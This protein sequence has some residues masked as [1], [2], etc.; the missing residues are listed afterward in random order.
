MLGSNSVTE[1]D[2]LTDNG[3]YGFNGYSPA[4]D[5]NV[6]VANNEISDN[7]T[8]TNGYDHP[9]GISCGCAGGGKFWDTN[10]ITFT[11]NWV[12]NNYDPA[13]WLDTNNAGFDISG[14]YINNN[15]AEGIQVEI[16]YNGL[17]SDNTLVDNGWVY[18]PTNPDFPTGAI[19]ISESGG[20]SRVSS[21]YSG[22]LTITGNTLTDNWSGVVLWENSN[23]FCSDGSDGVCTLVAPSKYTIAS[24][25]ANLAT[26]TPGE[27][28]DYFDNCRWKTQNVS[29][30]GNTFNFTPANIPGTCTRATAC[31]QNA[32]FSEYGSDE[33]FTG[34]VVPT[35]ISLHQN[36]SFSDNTYTGP[37]S[38]VG[39]SQGDVVTWAQWTGGFTDGSG[40]GVT[41]PG[42]DS[43]S[44]Y[45]GSGGGGTTTTTTVPPTTTTTTVPPTTTT[46]TVPPTTT[47]TTTAPAP[48]PNPSF[49]LTTT[50]VTPTTVAPWWLGSVVITATVTPQDGG[51][52]TGTVTV[53]A[54]STPICYVTL[55]AGTGSCSPEVA[56]A[57]GS[58]AITGSYG[59]DTDFYGSTGLATTLTVA[60]PFWPL[61]MRSTSRRP[62]W[63]TATKR[64]PT[65]RLAS[66]R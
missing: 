59:G 46:T 30:T 21:T 60:K 27:S 4:G 3:Q 47:T 38:F 23:R 13:V 54:G 44:A 50:T 17:I 58:Y 1:D 48:P 53:L 5:T 62:A 37:W 26:S 51:T 41:F 28:P 52:P 45:N 57:T 40:S 16:S 64:S 43:G 61:S 35:N 12:H 6:T 65:T 2:C 33:P 22:S 49:T 15:S 20:D 10:G 7:D 24:C 14:N 8:Q 32:L 39:F 55:N 63:F 11:G 36:N 25:G 29:V 56:L 31:G 9:G 18:G 34:W 42:Q 19:Y 66:R